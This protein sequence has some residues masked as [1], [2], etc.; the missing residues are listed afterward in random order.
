MP[1]E[2]DIQVIM[3]FVAVFLRKPDIFKKFV[4]KIEMVD[5]GDDVS[6]IME[7]AV[8]YY[9]RYKKIPTERHYQL[10]AGKEDNKKLPDIIKTLFSR[11][12]AGEKY[13]LDYMNAIISQIVTESVVNEVVEMKDPAAISSALYKAS[14]DIKSLNTHAPYWDYAD[15]FS[16]REERRKFLAENPSFVRVL[17]LGIK[18]LDDQVKI[19]PGMVIGFLAPFKKYKSITLTNVGYAAL[20]QGM[21]VLHVNI[22][23]RREMW[24][25]RYDSRFTGVD[26]KRLV[27]YLRTSDE[28]DRIASVFS[29][30]ESMKNRLKI[31]AGV[32]KKTN[33]L[34]IRAMV[35]E[36]E[37]T[38]EI[39]VD[40]IIADYANIMGS[41]RK[42]VGED[43]EVQEAIVWELIGLASEVDNEK[44][45]VTAFQ[46]K[47]AGVDVDDLKKSHF[48]RSLAIPQ[49]LDAAIAINQ[50]ENEKRDGVLR[51][52][53]L[54]LRDGDV[55]QKDCKVEPELWKMSVSKEMDASLRSEL[56]EK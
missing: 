11:D 6:W 24:E 38:E 49:A 37:A 8:Q 21:T 27:E 55:V 19:V 44:I 26:Y 40:V 43:H 56:F 36:I 30:I 17:K 22:E 10:E 7:K 13:S 46:S 9:K 32:Y 31:A 2:V 1:F 14:I 33:A 54:F 53:P 29:K 25:A 5:F 45:V 18:E 39:T 50:S 28:Q 20:L 15:G 52:S 41:T 35:Q 48:G 3:D 12:I 34:D 51:Y 16:A 23:G 47:A 4:S 42:I